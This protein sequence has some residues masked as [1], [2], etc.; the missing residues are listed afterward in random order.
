MPKVFVLLISLIFTLYPVEA[1]T[2]LTFK[3]TSPIIQKALLEKDLTTLYEHI[4]LYGI[5]RSKIRK[6]SQKAEQKKALRYKILSKTIG[7]SKS[8]LTKIVSEIVIKE[9]KVTPRAAVKA[10]LNRL[11]ITGIG[12]KGNMGYAYGTFL[13]K[14]FYLSAVKNK[15]NWLIV[16]AG[17]AVI[18]H[19]MDYLLKALNKG[20]Q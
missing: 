19:E 10:Y 1:K 20:N 12:E 6:L 5:V 3:Q 9:Y 11:K 13:G 4:D 2:H 7:L 16:G 15:G 18:D 14:P 17:S 8:V